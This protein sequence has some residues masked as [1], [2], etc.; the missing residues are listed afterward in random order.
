MLSGDLAL[1]TALVGFEQLAAGRA[2]ALVAR[3][4][5]RQLDAA[6]L[7]A[8]QAGRANAYSSPRLSKCHAIV[9]SLR[10][11]ATVAILR[12]RRAATRS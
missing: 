5:E 4:I 7:L 12:P 1:G 10:A 9:T 11:V 6:Q 8:I 2:A 3:G